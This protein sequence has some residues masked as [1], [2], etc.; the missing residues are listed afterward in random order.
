MPPGERI[1]LARAAG[2]EA[3]WRSGRAILT[4][5]AAGRARRTARASTRSSQ[6]PLPDVRTPDAPDSRRT[7][8]ARGGGGGGG[9]GWAGAS[10]R[11]A[12][13]R[14]GSMVAR[15]EA[16]RAREAWSLSRMNVTAP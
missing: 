1:A 13:E 15:M 14:V 2:A 9:G 3:L 10:A 16:F 11:T 6:V 8:A 5:L 12:P 7:A 4:G